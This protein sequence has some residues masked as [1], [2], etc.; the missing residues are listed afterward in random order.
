MA[1][2]PNS[3]SLRYGHECEKNVVIANSAGAVPRAFCVRYKQNTAWP[4]C[5]SLAICDFDFTDA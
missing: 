5:A 1:G 2:W 3:A 4:E